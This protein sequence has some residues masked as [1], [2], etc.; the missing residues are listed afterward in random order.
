MSVA[1]G[2]KLPTC[3]ALINESLIQEIEVVNDLTN[4]LLVRYILGF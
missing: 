3:A 4:H 1:I 2:K